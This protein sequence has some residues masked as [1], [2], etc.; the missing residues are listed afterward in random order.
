VRDGGRERR[1]GEREI[2][3]FLEAFITLLL[4][5]LSIKDKGV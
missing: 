5:Y 4:M 2:L 1:F 3:N